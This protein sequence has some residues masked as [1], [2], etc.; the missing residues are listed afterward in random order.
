MGVEGQ[1]APQV[2]GGS[3]EIFD[4]DRPQFHI[5][6]PA[7]WMNDPNGPIFYKGRYHMY[8]SDCLIS[9]VNLGAGT[10]SRHISV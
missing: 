6:P 1:S 3:E 4:D 2:S 9:P 7:G 8:V 10:A 5:Q